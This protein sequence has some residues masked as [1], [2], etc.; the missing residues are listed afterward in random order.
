VLGRLALLVSASLILL[1][2]ALS[3]ARQPVADAD[4]LVNQVVV[5]GSV[6]EIWRLLTTK[7]GME[8]WIVPHADVDLRVGGLVRTHHDPDGK[9]GDPKTVTNRILAVKPKRLVSLQLAKAPDGLP[10]AEAV[11]NT[12]YEVSLIPLSRE[13][14]RVRC[15]ARGF[16]R[17][18]VAFAARAFVDRG[19]A[20]AL[21]QL[22]KVF[23]NRKGKRAAR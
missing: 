20:W 10:F 22:Q 7:E 16:G 12:W 14:T 11:L 17:G 19:N 18:P 2:P 1:H 8:S 9:I 6:D 15:V 13:R 23:S 21:Q 3:A 5:E 4:A